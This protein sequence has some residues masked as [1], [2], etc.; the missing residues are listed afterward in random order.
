MKT[1]I[2]IYSGSISAISAA[3]VLKSQGKDVLLFTHRNYLG[4]DLC[5]SLRLRL[6]EDLDLSHPL[7][8][9]LY[10]D[11]VT[12]GQT[13]RP[14]HIKH[15]LDQVLAEADIPV[16]LG[17]AP[18]EFI[19]DEDGLLEGLRVHNRS[20]DFEISFDTLIDGSLQ[21]DLFRLAG[22]PL[23]A[24]HSNIE[25]TR[26]VIGGEAT[27]V[28][29]WKKEGTVSFKDGE[30][31]RT[32]PLWSYTTTETL[33]DSSWASWMDLEQSIRMQAYRPGQDQ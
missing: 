5:D 33:K 16:M 4:E 31:T 2:L 22:V 7:A 18:A 28:A 21:G 13:L 6:P 19:R 11:A 9:R 20:G 24:P 10:T 12:Q 25:V 8:K 30:T 14:M 27:A 1:D 26:R 32:E 29:D 17:N 15:E 23:T 3:L